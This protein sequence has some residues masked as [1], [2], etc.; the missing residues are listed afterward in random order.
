MHVWCQLPRRPVVTLEDVQNRPDVRGI[1]INE[2]GISG[3]RYPIVVW[4]REQGKQTTVAEITMSVGLPADV[5]GTHL[6]RFIELLH[7]N[8]D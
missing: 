1:A 2:V 4:D 3:I 7:E 5:K 8:S 6:S